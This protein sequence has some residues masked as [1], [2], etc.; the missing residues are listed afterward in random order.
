MLPSTLSED[1]DNP[2]LEVSISIMSG[3]V[4]SGF[5]IITTMLSHV[6]DKERVPFSKLHLDLE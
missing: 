1:V 6:N 3:G 4:N 2:M 5:K